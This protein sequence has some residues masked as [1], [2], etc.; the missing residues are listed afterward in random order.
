MITFQSGEERTLYSLSLRHMT[1]IRTQPIRFVFRAPTGRQIPVRQARK[2]QYYT[3][4]LG[5]RGNFHVQYADHNFELSPHGLLLFSPDRALSVT[6][7]EHQNASFLAVEFELTPASPFPFL[8]DGF[9]HTENAKPLEIILHELQELSDD[10]Y[11]Y[12]EALLL[13]LFEKIQATKKDK[14]NSHL[15]YRHANAYI[16]RHFADPPTS[17]MISFGTHYSADHLTKLLKRSHGHSLSSLITRERLE[18]IKNYLRFT[19]YTTERIA[20]VLAFPSANAMIRFFK[21]HTGITPK[22][23]RKKLYKKSPDAKEK[24]H[25]RK[26]FL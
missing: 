26:I 6:A 14:G 7:E 5:Q 19:S 21:Y 4:L 10:R 1:V 8:T 22:E 15:L 24:A 12:G 13:I 17:A 23:Y 11:A 3:F 2:T 9:Y 25:E 20:S 16:R 18:N